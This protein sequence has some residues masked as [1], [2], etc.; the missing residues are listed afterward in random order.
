MPELPDDDPR[1]EEFSTNLLKLLGRFI[2]RSLD[3]A[4][5]NRI[6]ILINDGRAAFKRR[7][8][9]DIPELVVLALPTSG[10]FAV[11]RA[12]LDSKTIQTMLLNLLREFAVRKVPVNKLELARAIRYAWPH[13]DPA[14][15]E[16]ATD[17]QAKGAF[18]N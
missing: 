5:F 6:K 16:F 18:I 4:E 3:L 2:G 7:Y 15:E 14:I 10:H 9:Y 17:G 11:F 8:G 1:I 12:D 13:Y